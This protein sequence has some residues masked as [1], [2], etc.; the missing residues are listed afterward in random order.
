M[1][2]SDNLDVLSVTNCYATGNVSC[3]VAD[4][5]AGLIGWR[6]S[7][8]L[9]G[10]YYN[11]SATQSSGVTQQT[12][13]GVGKEYAGLLS[14]NVDSKTS[15]DMKAPAFATTLGTGTWSAD[16]ST[17]N[18]GYPILSAVNAVSS[19]LYKITY[20]ANGST[21]G[22]APTDTGTYPTGTSVTLA[23]DTGALVKGG[24]TFG[25]WNTQGGGGTNYA[26]C[27]SYTVTGD[28]T[29]YAKWNSTTPA[30]TVSSISPTTGPTAG[31]TS[32]TITGTN[33]GSASAVKFGT[34]SATITSNT[35][36]QIVATSPSHTTA[37]AV[38]VTVTTAG[39]TSATSAADQFTYTASGGS[40]ATLFVDSAE[41]SG[42]AYCV[43]V[44]NNGKYLTA[45]YTCDSSYS[46]YDIT[47]VRYNSNGTLD[48]TFGTGGRTV[49]DTGTN[50][51]NGIEIV[52][53]SDG[54]IVVASGTKAADSSGNVF[55][56]IR[57]TADGALD[58]SFGTHGIVETDIGAILDADTADAVH[59]MASDASGNIYLAGTVR[60]NSGGSGANY[61]VAKY[62]SGGILDESYGTHG[63]TV[64]DFDGAGVGNHYCMAAAFD[65]GGKLVVG[66][67]AYIGTTSYAAFVRLDSN[68]SLDPD[69]GTGGILTTTEIAT[70][71]QV[72]A[73]TVQPVSNKI[74]AAGYYT[75]TTILSPF[76]VSL[77]DA[78]AVSAIFKTRISED[79]GN[80]DQ[81]RTIAC[82]S[83]GGIYIVNTAKTTSGEYT[84]GVA[85]VKSDLSALDSTFN[86][87]G[88]VLRSFGAMNYDEAYGVA[89]DSNSKIVVVGYS[90]STE[91]RC[92]EALIRLNADGSIDTLGASAPAP[93][94]TAVSPASGTTAGG[95][96]VTITGTN[97][98]GATG[99]DAVKF[100]STNATAYTVDTATQITA[101]SPAGSG[102]VDIT[103][104][105]TGGTS[106]TSAADQFTY[107]AAPTV[108]ITSTASS[109]TNSSPIP[110]TIT[111]SESVTGFTSGD[112]TVSNGSV[113][114]FLG[115]G[116]TYTAGI[117]PAANG[118]VTV[119]IA[120]NVAQ[121]A[122]GNGNTAATQLSRI[123]DNTQ[124]TVAI[125]SA[126]S[127][128]T[129]T[130]PIPVTINFSES[131]TEFT[132]GDITVS[133][134]SVTNFLGS[135]TSYTADITPAANGTVTVNIASNAAQ[136]AA[137]NGNTAATQLSRIY[138]NTQPSVTITSAASNPTNTSP[139][140]VTINFSESVT[141]FT[142][143]DITVSNGSVTNFLGSG[144][145]Y[146]ADITPAAN[147]AVMVNI[148]SNAAQ[149]AAGN[150]NT[151][152]TQLSRTYDNTQPTVAITSIAL[153]P[154]NTSP[155]PVTMTFSESVTG[156]EAADITVTNG[157]KGTLSGSGASYTINVTPSGQGAVTVD[158]AAG[159]ATDAAGNTNTVATQ[160]SRTFDTVAPTVTLSSTAANPTNTSLVP[161]AITFSESVT[162]FEAADITVTNGTKGTLSGSGASYTISVTPSGQG[163]VTVDI[164]AGIAT[165]AAGN[166]NTEA[167]Q[168]S[169][170]FDTVAPTVTLS[171]TAANPTN[172]S[173][174]PVAITF[175]E[176]V[177]GFEAADITVTNGTKGTLSGSDASYTI[178]VTPSG[179]GAVTVDIA[180]GIAQDAAGNGNTA[181][182]QLSRTY[183]N[184]QPSVTIT[185][186]APNPTNTSPI[187]VTI[188]F[189]E[190]VSDFTS[191]DISV[192]N[193]SVTKLLGSGT[194][195]TAEI[196][197]T[198][199]DGPVTV[200]V[201]AGAA[202][203]AAGNGNTVAAQLS[204]TYDA[205]PPTTP[206]VTSASQ[207]TNNR[208]PT[209]TWTSAG[210]GNGTYRYKLD[211]SD[212]S[213]D[214]TTT[215]DLS[216]TPET[217][218]SESDH[219]L[220]VQERDPAG[221]WSL[222]GSFEVTV[223]ITPPP[224]TGIS[225]NTAYHSDVTPVFTESTATLNTAGFTSGTA[226]SGEGSYVLVVTDGAG[227]STT[228]NFSIDKTAP[229]VQSISRQTPSGET[230]NATSVIYR[231][232]FSE[233]VTGVGTDDF[234]L[235]AATGMVT[236][237]ASSVSAPNGTTIDVTVS[238]I[239]GEGT[240]RLDLKSSGTGIT[241]L[242]GNAIAGGYAGGQ[243]Y[244]TDTVAPAVSSV[245]V[246]SDKTYIVGQ[247]LEF[248]V[249]FSENVTV[250]D[251][252]PRIAVT[253]GTGGT[254]Y[255]NYVSGSG[256]S[257][258][259]FSYPVQ[260]GE[261]D[262]NGITVGSL[263]SNG[264]T[265]RDTAAN[266]AILTLNSVGD[267]SDVLV[268][269]IAPVV[270]SVSAPLDGTYKTLD[271]LDFTVHYSETVTV[272]G[273]PTIPVALDTGGTVN[274]SYIGGSS[275]PN[276]T[277][278]YTVQTGNLDA[279]GVSLGSYIS[280]N[281][282]TLTDV[283]GNA[284]GLDLSS[285]GSLLEVKVDAVAPTVSSV[286][287][288]AN[289]IYRTGQNLD[290]TVNFS[291][292]VVKSGDPYFELTIGSQ[293]KHAAYLSGSGTSA[294]VFRYAVAAED[295][296]TD[297][298]AGGGLTLNSGTIKDAAGNNANITLNS[299]GSTTD[300][301]VDA[302]APTIGSAALS[303]DNTYMDITFSEGIYGFG[304]GTTALTTAKLALTFTKNA[305]SA[306]GAS[307]SSVKKADNAT[308][309]LASALTGGETTVRVF[310]S[311]TGTPSGVETVEIKP[312]SAASVY[313]LAGNAMAT[314]QTSGAKTLSDLTAPAAG[315]SGVVTAG[316]SSTNSV[317]LSWTA[318]ADDV[319]A[320]AG[321]Q[322]KIVRS[323]SNNM[324][325]VSDA[326]SNGTI[327]QDWTANVTSVSA[328][329]LSAGTTYYFNVIV[330]DS[331]GNK[332]IYTS[333][334][335]ATNEDSD[336][337]V[338]GSP[339]PSAGAVIEVNGQTQDAGTLSTSTEDGKTVTTVT[340]D[341]TKL[342]EKLEA[343]GDGATVTIPVN[344]NSD[345]VVGQLNGQT[346]K[347]METKEA[348]LEIKTEN[349]TYTLPASQ[350]NIDS[351][352]SQIGEQVELQDIKVSIS[353]AAPS[354]DTAKIV[355]DTANKN[356]YQ[357][358]V[359]PIE[360]EI[361]CTSGG[362]TVDVSK[363][364]G[365][366]E[367]TVAIPDGIDPSKITTGIVLNNDGT[368]SHVP[369]TIVI[370]GG[371]YFAKINSLTNSVY[372][373]IYNPVEFN[374]VA[375]HW[376]KDAIND[377]GSRLVINGFGNND[378]RPQVEITRAEFATIIVKALGL[379]AG[380]GDSKFSDVKTT[381]WYCGYIE[382]ASSYGIITGYS[383]GAFGP[384]DKITRE[385]AM[386]M[387]E[388]A[389]KLTKLDPALT[390]SEV[391]GLLGSYA[392]ASVASGYAKSSIAACLRTGVVT[393]K[394]GNTIAPKDYITRAEVAVIVQRLLQKSN[395]I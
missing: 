315:G 260:T 314:A 125:T 273:I 178:S 312:A 255:A 89:V 224:V 161:V 355:Q 54:K 240:L 179:Q 218:L 275:T 392:D 331:A 124:P 4:Y 290:F 344:N 299:V 337:G 155:I 322:Y 328:S 128:P 149:D 171:S 258:L 385:Q 43:K 234:T 203:D 185:S 59:A 81:P 375:S 48:T 65:A 99:A 91:E 186:A 259:V 80:S 142:S 266:D 3:S 25:G 187:P 366:V 313:D 390:D 207:L 83:A 168:L 180:A 206:V 199:A 343:E 284:A 277:F 39:G 34:E 138:D 332:T 251:G 227:N 208:K 292:T 217:N 193:G 28:V 22:A 75:D 72:T 274:A 228:V 237:T 174:V 182:T 140:P 378:Y 152:A 264:A 296:D 190:S 383:N 204:R 78:G 166:T 158:I 210:G 285:I 50:Y 342:E 229:F 359:K 269:G 6:D 64:I 303:S 340:I 24:Y 370:I 9:T 183:D 127:N 379:R 177:T 216:Y 214:T 79:S 57:L 295:L 157:T 96:S 231:V 19:T 143:G 46:V 212:F 165:D 164:A 311:L 153:N 2:C 336:G 94:I 306:T 112:I 33:L 67:S 148:A 110:V 346:V 324:T 109:F 197:P 363:F 27:A 106:A 61:A 226:I 365:Y 230:T 257:A 74:I 147:G 176:S 119:N 45:G 262:T 18:Q 256:T 368:F 132:S 268:D 117:T 347:N 283:N 307:I 145:S 40:T 115:S 15:T 136:D 11:S 47:V 53:Q 92:D 76:V 205:T 68:G 159:V 196:T 388:R 369:T 223:D 321:L 70:Y 267:T 348:V 341:D 243:T 395:L 305:G 339:N 253:L 60:F 278:R 160:L 235:T 42:S 391:S 49:V 351:V 118:T 35:A 286:G 133:N 323:S 73:I 301:K 201:A 104:T 126:V 241:D 169:R 252:T 146:T 300:V 232:T 394:S 93:T 302:V 123:Y 335:K 327:V 367:R 225:N 175:S 69:F 279:T 353:I 137:G 144:T 188:T 219:V 71:A 389:M 29:L 261:R 354:Q 211:S 245:T 380:T 350:I 254:V 358:V 14:S 372:S 282:G 325:T 36:T 82:D 221:N 55:T 63:V 345:V 276:L 102:T 288:P 360:F 242:S 352:S 374:D 12:S 56:M 304:D 310:L 21:G 213:S 384:N 87:T 320:Q 23:A 393:G 357:V 156:F 113:N 51:D 233:A 66:G 98:T 298:I 386:A 7:G 198:T 62:S 309:S 280:L 85:K 172:T 20:D 162:G 10:C 200:D 222:S 265:I 31:G 362:K 32:V 377:M 194:S 122:A 373:V 270:S 209:W 173:L 364:N 248:T 317:P 371:K 121:D 77:T 191:S 58:T 1:D 44:L 202:H 120:S 308:E 318:A 181:A 107:V 41:G 250:A 108:T 330:K 238:S 154:T 356:S 111:F 247:S 30:P 8:I 381:D 131:V 116:T 90:Q 167:T 316:D 184:T 129:N 263:S 103:V 329:N 26:V 326:E 244:S 294:V 319:T 5:A 246:P 134:G 86:A 382:T 289:G 297:G 333:V 271:T 349:V 293:T 291:E 101:T 114:N 287:V 170:T 13:K 220:Y 88:T 192:V 376:A 189:S 84:F 150:G 334:S 100:G 38:H 239:A 16:A 37:E 17:K 163:A 195:Y 95:T 361:T 215:T 272:T 52:V 249:N 387:I 338:T 281:S 139:I 135:G 97:F 141:G 236:G 130:S 105:T 151:A